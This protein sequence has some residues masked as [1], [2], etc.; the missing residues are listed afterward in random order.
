LHDGFLLEKHMPSIWKRASVTINPYRVT[1]FKALGVLMNTEVLAPAEI[2]AI[3][4][5]Q[6]AGIG[7]NLGV[8]RFGE[9]FLEEKHITQALEI[10][11][12]PTRRILEELLEH[13]PE[14][15]PADDLERFKQRLQRP[16][17]PDSPP[18]VE[19]FSFLLRVVQDLARQFASELPP[20]YPSPFPVDLTPLAA[21]QRV[22]KPEKDFSTNSE[23]GHS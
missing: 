14:A 10:L 18:E 22:K 16:P 9:E 6:K 15:F 20:V 19:N 11:L 1:A 12:N 21:F 2:D 4:G 13:Q 7:D 3:A 5:Q 8:Y 17:W 23:L